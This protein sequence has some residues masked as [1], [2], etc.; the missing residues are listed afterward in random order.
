MIA[1]VGLQSAEF[2]VNSS[3]RAYYNFNTKPG[4]SGNRDYFF[5]IPICIPPQSCVGVAL[6][7]TGHS[8]STVTD[9][10]AV[11]S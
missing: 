8:K 2:R 11:R 4:G 10:N 6:L 3:N 5:L 9:S 1:K 7:G